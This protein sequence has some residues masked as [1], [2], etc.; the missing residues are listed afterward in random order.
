M[1]SKDL[2]RRL[3]VFVVVFA[4]VTLILV[5]LPFA[6]DWL[7]Q[8][9]YDQFNLVINEDNDVVSTDGT[10]PSQGARTILGIVVNLILIIKIILW[11]SLVV[12]VVRLITGLVCFSVAVNR[13]RGG[14]L[15]A[16]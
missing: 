14:E 3:S 8:S 12:A 15:M 10:E 5:C 13:R 6:E 1:V 4:V 16:V 9:I 7:R 2:Q 11:M